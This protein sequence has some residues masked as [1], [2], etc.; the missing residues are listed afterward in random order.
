MAIVN[1]T[2]L[3]LSSVPC[4]A[5]E[6]SIVNVTIKNCLPVTMFTELVFLH[7]LKNLQMVFPEISVS[8]IPHWWLKDTFMI[9][10][11]EILHI[12][13]LYQHIHRQRPPK[14]FCWTY[15]IIQNP[16]TACDGLQSVFQRTVEIKVAA[17]VCR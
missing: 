7:T 17:S 4:P 16:H 2:C 14:P 11:D 12:S 1:T 3:A 13:Q 10:L 9:L 8:M 6:A 5:L 15:Q